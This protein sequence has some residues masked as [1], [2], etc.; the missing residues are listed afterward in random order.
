MFATYGVPVRSKVHL[1]MLALSSKAEYLF[2]LLTTEELS[3]YSAVKTA[4]LEELKVTPVEHRDRF[5][6]A[7]KHKDEGNR[8][9]RGGLG[10][11]SR[12][13]IPLG[14]LQLG[15]LRG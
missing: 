7:M 3:R 12:P 6:K 11:L 2:S 15:R 1:I 10:R 4:V 8:P 14:C 9:P 13:A 5:M